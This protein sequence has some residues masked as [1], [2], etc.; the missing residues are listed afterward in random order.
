M[1]ENKLFKSQIVQIRLCKKI[2]ECNSLYI[3]KLPIF[4]GQLF[5]IPVPFHYF[6]FCFNFYFSVADIIVNHLY[7]LF[8][9]SCKT[10]TNVTIKTEKNPWLEILLHFKRYRFLIF[11]R[12]DLVVLRNCAQM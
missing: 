9:H 2:T 1:C 6:I 10:N 7:I 8:L 12:L 4:S 11:L 5:V 3:L